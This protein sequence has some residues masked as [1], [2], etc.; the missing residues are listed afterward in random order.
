MSSLGG[1]SKIA[2]QARLAPDPLSSHRELLPQVAVAAVGVGFAIMPFR[3]GA[4]DIPVSCF[5]Q[6]IREFFF[7][8][9]AGRVEHHVSKN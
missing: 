3:A 2:Q 4:T 1:A 6:M 7:T 9:M 5:T 8:S